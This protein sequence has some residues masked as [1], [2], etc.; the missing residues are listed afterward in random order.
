VTHAVDILPPAA[1]PARRIRVRGLVQG[2]GFRPHVYR[3]AQ[4]FGIEGSVANGPEGVVIEARGQNLD[5]FVAAVRD[6]LPALARIDSLVEMPLAGADFP[7]QENPGPVGFH[8]GET[9]AGIV[10]GAAIPADTAICSRCLREL[11]D[12]ADRRYLHPFIAC[13]D[14]GP[15]YSMSRSLPYDRA[16][17]SMADFALCAACERDYSDPGSRRFHAEPVACHDC[18]PVL[19]RPIADAAR[20]IAAGE[21]VALKGIGGYHLVCDARRDDTVR[22]LRQRKQR[23]GKPLAV[24]VLN[25]ASARCLADFDAGATALLSGPHRPV[26]VAPRRAGASALSPAVTGGLDS[27]GTLLPYS[28]LHYLLFHALLGA[29]SGHAWLEQANE[30]ALVM[31]SANLSGDPLLA[32]PGEAAVRLAGIADLLVHHDREIARRVDDSVVRCAQGQQSVIRR[33]R[34]FAPR[35]I[36]LATQ[37]PAVLALGAHLKSTVAMTRGDRAYL[38]AHVGDLDTPA[39]VAFHAEVA[40]ALQAELQ[41]RPDRI[42]CDL[43]RDFAS[44]RLAESL[45]ERWSVPLVRVQH[46]HAHA[47]AV[48][49]EHR[50]EEPALAVVLDGHG[51][52]PGQQAWGGELLRVDGAGF[53]RLGHFAPLPLPGGDR[54]AREP[55]RLGAGALH[56]LGRGEEIATRFAG[57]P[58]ASAL[59]QWLAGGECPETSAAGRLFDAAAALLGLCDIACYEGEAP[60]RLESAVRSPRALPGGYT[61]DNGVVSFA[62]LLRALADCADPVAGADWFHGTL[63][64][65]ISAWVAWA[66]DRTGL[67]TVLLAGGCLV[68]ARLAGGVLAGLDGRGLQLLLPRE[69]PPGDGAVS[70]GQAWVA[71]HSAD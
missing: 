4:R 69:M 33:A 44:T 15:R 5:A 27:L 13:C 71:R 17:T 55:W 31:T 68:N 43:S 61:L 9:R 42:A 35:A 30:L 19:S 58:M 11:F 45:S 63:A 16:T 64:D 32:D 1:A 52:G 24:M 22:R 46:H 67:A 41:A 28:G 70:L 23:E 65:A 51:E 62:P 29:P 60:M 8:I 34:G 40:A 26:V 49:A 36:R 2:V 57:Q 20:A 38:S 53:E 48:L 37:G 50:C 59:Q 39:A 6:E 14:C 25:A 47:A 10:N 12:P 56:Q 21:I 7:A 66:A 54:A 18:G 3:C